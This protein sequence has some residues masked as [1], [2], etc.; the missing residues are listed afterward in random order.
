MAEV[1]RVFERVC[2]EIGGKLVP[3]KLVPNNDIK[4][5]LL[6]DNVKRVCRIDKGISIYV[7]GNYMLNGRRLARVV[8]SEPYSHSPGPV[9]FYST[10][11][12]VVKVVKGKELVKERIGTESNCIFDYHDSSNN[13]KYIAIYI[14]PSYD[15]LYI[16]MYIA[17]EY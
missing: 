5:E 17:E 2:K 3:S 6:K 7:E 12:V 4:S 1:P 13:S 16:V 14:P 15:M 11:S 9:Q 10:K 8:F